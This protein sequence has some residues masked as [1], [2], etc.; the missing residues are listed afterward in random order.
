MKFFIYQTNIYFGNCGKFVFIFTP[1]Y[2]KYFFMRKVYANF[3]FLWYVC[4][5]FTLRKP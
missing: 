2:Q 3:I 5:K 4:A 1:N